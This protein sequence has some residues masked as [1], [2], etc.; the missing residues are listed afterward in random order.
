MSHFFEGTN[1]LAGEVDQPQEEKVPQ[2]RHSP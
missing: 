2:L 1:N